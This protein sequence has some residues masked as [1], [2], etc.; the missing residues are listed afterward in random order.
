MP[1]PRVRVIAS[2]KLKDKVSSPAARAKRAL[3]VRPG[4]VRRATSPVVDDYSSDEGD[5]DEE[6]E[7]DYDTD[8]IASSNASSSKRKR[9][10]LPWTLQQTLLQDITDNGGID[11]FQLGSNQALKLLC[12]KRKTVYGLFSVLPE[13]KKMEVLAEKNEIARAKLMLAMTAHWGKGDNDD[14]LT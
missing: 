10:K 14:M 13:D 7:T 2:Q 11:R 8:S 5:L 4:A 6:E 12:S 9:E 3:A 1:S